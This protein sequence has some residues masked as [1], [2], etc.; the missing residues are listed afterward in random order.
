M[1]DFFL[2]IIPIYLACSP[3]RRCCIWTGYKRSTADGSSEPVDGRHRRIWRSS[4]CPEHF[5]RRDS[6]IRSKDS[7]T[8]QQGTIRVLTYCNTNFSFLHDMTEGSSNHK[9]VVRKS[10]LFCLQILFDVYLFSA[11]HGIVHREIGSYFRC[12]LK[13]SVGHDM[14]LFIGKS[15]FFFVVFCRISVGHGMALFIGKFVVVFFTEILKRRVSQKNE[16]TYSTVACARC[17][18]AG[19]NSEKKSRPG[20]QRYSSGQPIRRAPDLHLIS[21]S[22]F[23]L[24]IF[25][26]VAFNIYGECCSFFTSHANPFRSIKRFFCI[27]VPAV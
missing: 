6:Y 4:R 1:H 26:V 21:C 15:D 17:G 7:H 3:P 12:I 13:I 18:V 2:P 19:C 24:R 25:F 20:L 8:Q 22:S 16:K 5:G 27:I 14:A 10:Y 11:G 9:I 23:S